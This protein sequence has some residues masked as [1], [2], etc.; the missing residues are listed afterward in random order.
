MK[1]YI[2][3][4]ISV[5]SLKLSAQDLGLRYIDI[6]KGEEGLNRGD[7]LTVRCS[8]IGD[9]DLYT[10]IGYYLS[11]DTVLDS[12]DSL[13]FTYSR[14]YS[15]GAWNS[16]YRIDCN[17]NFYGWYYIIGHLD[18]N[19]EIAESN[20][21]NNILVTDSFFID[22]PWHCGVKLELEKDYSAWSDPE[23]LNNGFSFD[24]TLKVKSHLSY[25]DPRG[26]F[27]FFL[28]EDK[29]FDYD[30]IVLAVAPPELI[31][32]PTQL[33]SGVSYSTNVKLI[34]SW[35]N[36][37]PDGFYY[38][39]VMMMGPFTGAQ[40]GNVDYF[41]Y[42]FDFDN[43]E[44]DPNGR[45]KIGNPSV[46][47]SVGQKLNAE[48]KSIVAHYNIHGQLVSQLK[49]LVTYIVKFDDGTFEKVVYQNL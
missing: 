33:D 7:I 35:M 44:E 30:D 5:L 49:P 16:S 11:R 25:N 9:D 43:L 13:L 10:D 47:V 22:V 26:D 18:Y 3:I 27:M 6:W 19:N 1:Q 45:I 29:S 46:S 34:D 23:D 39:G 15:S 37:V 21:E 20:E 40:N 31:D 17:A 28:S 41:G 12:N 42:Y 36:R 8:G 4:V 32:I 2:L 14:V 48:E 24:A 38:L